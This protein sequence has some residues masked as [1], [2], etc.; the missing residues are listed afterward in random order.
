MDSSDSIYATRHEADGSLQVSTSM[1]VLC[2]GHAAIS[3]VLF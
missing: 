3:S 1:S 2:A